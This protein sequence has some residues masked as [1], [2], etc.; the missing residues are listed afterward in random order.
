MCSVKQEKQ[1]ELLMFA[2][3]RSRSDGVHGIATRYSPMLRHVFL[4]S[5]AVIAAISLAVTPASAQRG[6]DRDQGFPG[7]QWNAQED[8]EQQ[9]EVPL[10]S[11]LRDLRGRY[12]GQH[13]DAQKAGG[14]YIIAW[15]TGDG[16]RLTIEVDA[17]TGRVLSTR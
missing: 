7:S 12:G 4:S 2:G 15:V 16:R 13:L 3:F 6:R 5:L 17:A 1:P 14:R 8:R 9:R 11:I 10:S